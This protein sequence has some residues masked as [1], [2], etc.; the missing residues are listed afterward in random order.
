[1]IKGSE[2]HKWDLHVH[3]LYSHTNSRYNC[4]MKEIAAKILAEKISV[5]GVTNY[6]IVEEKEITELKAELGESVYLIPNFEFRI[7][8][9]NKDGEY[10]NIH[11]LFN[12]ETTTITKIQESLSRIEL[13]NIAGG[14]KTYCTLE[15]VKT[16]GSDKITISLI[17]LCDQ[18]NKDFKAIEDFIIVGVNKGYGGFCPGGKPRDQELAL[19]IDN[20]SDFI[21]SKKEDVEFFL[22]KVAGRKEL[23]LIAKA[24][25]ECSDAHSVSEIGNKYSWIKAEPTFEGLKQIIYEPSHRIIIS[26][27]KPREPIRKIESI[28]FDFPVNTVIKKT[29]SN[30]QQ[31][32]CIKHLKNEIFFSPYFTCLIGGRGTGKSTII[33]I[34]AEKL[35]VRTDFF[36]RQSNTI[37]IDNKVFD[38]EN[39][40]RNIIEVVGTEEIEFISQGRVE[41]LAE[42]DE[43]TKLVFTE[44]IKE[45]ENSF[46]D[47]ETDFNSYILNLDNNIKLLFELKGL[48]ETLK[49]KEKEKSNSQKIVDSEKDPRYTEITEEIKKINTEISL[50]ETSKKQYSALL[51]SVKDIIA[52]TSL[53]DDENEYEKRIKEIITSLKALEE[54]KEDDNNVLSIQLKEFKIA[55]SKILVLTEK[56]LVEN[57]KLKDFFTEK[58]TSEESVKDSQKASENIARLSQTIESTGQRIAF[59]KTKL[60]ENAENASAIGDNY[61]QTEKL[62]STSIDSIN[63][64]L[65]SKNENVLE[66]KFTYEFN[67][68]TFK[69]ALFEEFYSTFKSYH[70]ANT[71]IDKVGEVLFLVDPNEDL[72]SLNYDGFIKILNSAIDDNGYNRNTNYVTIINNIFASKT[73]FIAYKTLIQKHLYNLSKYI[74]IKGFYGNRELNACSF[75]Q[76]CTAVIVTLLM[77]GVKPLVI[78]EP[79]AHLDNRLIADYL[80]ELIKTKKLD[81]QIIFA[82]HNSNFV[83]NGDAE[84]IHI[85]EIPDNSIYTNITSTTIENISNRMKLL[86][87]EGGKEAFLSR[88]NKYGLHR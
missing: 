3:T 31:E 39:D 12:P 9:K 7:N 64:R 57:K 30:D 47:L 78:D 44:R 71:Q 55:E 32:L 36:N 23:N 24:I 33:N 75:G 85:L 49:E 38:F 68:D 4:T 59:I 25:V 17:E 81:R 45:I 22:N 48:N 74:K 40:T 29:G 26:D 79:E 66:I 70:L 42:G 20:L 65:K 46:Y 37:N 84:R 88:E 10:I 51:T 2:W 18:L 62:I 35:G 41:K 86:K 61:T 58:G 80:V 54:I 67:S 63:D 6:F 73:N 77:T 5:V 60:R 14:T 76:R 13:T 19:K 8:E 43:L 28:K 21:F 34:L 87:L 69:K 83:I 56:L 11:V 72:I 53:N 1:M 27:N 16:I 50:I 15:N 82:T 52:N